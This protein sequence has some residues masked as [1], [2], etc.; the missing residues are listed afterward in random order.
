MAAEQSAVLATVAKGD[1]AGL[2]QALDQ[3]GDPNA[4]GR[5]GVS[6]LAQAA[7]GGKLELVQLLLDKGAQVDKSSDAGNTALMQAAA[8]GHDQVVAALLAAGADPSHSNKWGNGP[9]DWAQ[10]P[11]NGAAIQTRLREPD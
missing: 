10:W 5:W 6:A 2:V 8:R 3:G 4:R 11:E 9:H 1:A 7:S